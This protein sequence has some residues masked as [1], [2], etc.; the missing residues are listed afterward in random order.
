MAF[1]W[2]NTI[3]A[4]SLIKAVVFEEM[5]DNLDT[6]DD[7]PACTDECSSD[8]GTEN[9]TYESSN[10]TGQLTTKYSGLCSGANS[11]YYSP[12]YLDDDRSE[13]DSC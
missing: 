4:G 10:L 13:N 1:I 9:G 5:Q 6:I 2:T 8:N 7:N 12:N 11:G 3:L